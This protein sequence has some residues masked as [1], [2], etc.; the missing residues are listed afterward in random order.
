[1]LLSKSK[2]NKLNQIE[3]RNFSL[4]YLEDINF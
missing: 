3:R 2:T 4:I 1:L